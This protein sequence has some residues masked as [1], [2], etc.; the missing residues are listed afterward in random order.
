MRRVGPLDA[1]VVGWVLSLL[2]YALALGGWASG[3]MGV[4]GA[5]E[6]SAVA[7]V[8]GI[9]CLVTFV[10][11][12]LLDCLK[13]PFGPGDGRRAIYVGLIVFLVPLGALFYYWSVVRP[14]ASKRKE[15]E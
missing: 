4:D 11:A 8:L 10:W 1:L 14:A 3:R 7:F 6:L 2:I 15:A 9:L 12:M 5:F 13:R